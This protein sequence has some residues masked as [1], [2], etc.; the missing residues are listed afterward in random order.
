M[1]KQAEA[2]LPALAPRSTDITPPNPIFQK[3]SR[4][5]FLA[6]QLF[7]EGPRIER[8]NSSIQS[9]VL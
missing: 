5:T 1:W 2:L 8:R 4:S 6:F 3:T 7:L 9:H